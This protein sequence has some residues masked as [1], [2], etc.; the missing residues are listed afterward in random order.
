M[1]KETDARQLAGKCGAQM[2]PCIVSLQSMRLSQ[3]IMCPYSG[4][5]VSVCM[6]TKVCQQNT[7][8]HTLVNGMTS[9]KCMWVQGDTVKAR[10]DSNTYSCRENQEGGQQST[11][12]DLQTQMQEGLGFRI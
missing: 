6:P 9:V 12:V 5:S 8:D 10:C 1:S 7:H 3:H 11:S 4:A 2:V